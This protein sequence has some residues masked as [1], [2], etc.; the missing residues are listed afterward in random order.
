[1]LSTSLASQ[2]PT[3]QM[4]CLLL[5]F[6]EDL[7]LFVSFHVSIELL[8]CIKE[9]KNLLRISTFLFLTFVI[10]FGI[11]QFHDLRTHICLFLCLLF[12]VIFFFFFHTRVCLVI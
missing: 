9:F 2:V 11:T 8:H 12:E 7:P 4:V 3:S 1:M 5:L 10:W 6:F